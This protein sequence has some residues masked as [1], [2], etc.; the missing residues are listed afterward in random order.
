M[1]FFQPM[2]LSSRRNCTTIYWPVFIYFGDDGP[3]FVPALGHFC[4]RKFL[5]SFLGSIRNFPLL[6]DVAQRQVKAH[7]DGKQTATKIAERVG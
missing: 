2:Q 5:R 6:K 4:L 3:H 7:A 1:T